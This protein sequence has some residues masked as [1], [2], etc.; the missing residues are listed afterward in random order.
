MLKAILSILGSALLVCFARTSSPAQVADP[1]QLSAGSTI[2]VM[3]E[4]WVDARKN[5]AGD[6]VVAKTT[7]NVKSDGRVVLPKGSKIIGHVTEA[8]A[9]TKEEP[10]SAVGIIFDHA[11][12]KDGRETPLALEIQ[13]IAPD[14]ASTPPAMGTAPGTAGGTT[15]AVPPLPVQGN[16]AGPMADPNAGAP[17]RIASPANSIGGAEGG[18]SP[19]GR[20]TPSCHGVLGIDG[21]ALIPET[22]DPVHGSV[23]AS[24]RRNVHLDGRT[25]MMLR[26]KDK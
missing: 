25:Q 21:L 13:A 12:L 11:V 24:L 26:V 23:I 6:E 18:L 14:E 22:S 20:L 19:A 3:L 10:E 16:A 4:K 7:E 15:G 17:G 1:I 8:K 9:R 2:P 5:K